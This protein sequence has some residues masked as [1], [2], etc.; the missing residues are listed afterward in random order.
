VTFLTT[1]KNK[2]ISRLDLN[3]AETNFPTTARRYADKWLRKRDFFCSSEEGNPAR[4]LNAAARWAIA[5]S[6]ARRSLIGI[7]AIA[8]IRDFPKTGLLHTVETP[9]EIVPD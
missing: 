4:L 1:A 5:A 7:N 8:G 2:F 3:E 9:E 6:K